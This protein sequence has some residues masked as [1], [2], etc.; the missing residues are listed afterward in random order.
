MSE[1]NDAY[2]MKQA[3]ALAQ[4]AWEQGEVPVG[5]ILVLD[6][7]VIGQGWNRPITRHDPTA[8]AEIMALQQGGQIGQ[9]YRL[10]NATLYVTLEPCVMCAGAMVHSRIKRLVYGA[11]DLK[12]GAA[13]SL[14]DV[15]RHPGMNHQIE[16]TAGV[17]ANECSEMLSQ[18]FQQRREQ[19]K[20]EREAR[21]L[22]QPDRA[23]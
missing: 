5:A 2:W 15:L 8:H 21:R 7:E 9:N 3:L 10:L 20:A 22:N 1:L 6:D 12:T 23:D 13:G 16:I 18:F 14:L 11:S 17:M 19:K 4:K